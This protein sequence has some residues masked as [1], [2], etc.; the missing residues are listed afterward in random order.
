MDVLSPGNLLGKPTTLFV[1]LAVAALSPRVTPAAQAPAPGSISWKR[2]AFE[3]RE[4]RKQSVDAEEGTLVVPLD[5]SSP[6]GARLALRLVRFRATGASPGAPIVY[7]AGGPGGSGILSAA[8][9]RFPLFQQ[10]REAGDVIALDQRGVRSTPFPSC[11]G[12]IQLPLDR[13]AGVDAWL[14]V[15][16]AASTACIDK[17][18]AEGINLAHF[19]VISSARDLEAL[20]A[21]LGAR[22]L[23]LLG[24]SFGTHLA[25][26]ALRGHPELADRVVLAGVEG[27]DDTLKLPSFADAHVRAVAAIADADPKRRGQPSLLAQFAAVAG[28]LKTPAAVTTIA[29]G[30]R[31]T[32]TMGVTDLQMALLELSA[33]RADIEALP[34]RLDRAAAGDLTDLARW[35]VARRSLPGLLPMAYVSDCASGASEARRAQIAREVPDSLMGAAFN[36]PFP[37]ICDTW[38]HRDAGATYRAPVASPVPALFIS[39]SLDGRTPLANARA[40]MRGFPNGHELLLDP[41]GHDD[42]LLIATPEIGRIIVGFFRGQAPPRPRLQLPALNFRQ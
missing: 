3:T 22:K 4:G 28:R 15:L 31:V 23:N 36:L 35:A 1:M 9:D 16:R 26:T 7:L 6:D 12:R 24:I 8:G 41:A 17:W 32:V 18:A 5:W 14:P 10:L 42:D 40:V 13:P 30:S 21:A 33:E 34:A 29:D 27:P 37:E 38:P 11:P 2:V 20:R 25:L 39:G 19:D